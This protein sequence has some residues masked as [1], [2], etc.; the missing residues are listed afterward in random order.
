[1]LSTELSRKKYNSNTQ[2]HA[3]LNRRQKSGNNTETREQFKMPHTSAGEKGCGVTEHVR[4]QLENG[5]D[6][7][8]EAGEGGSKQL[9]Q[10]RATAG[11][12][13]EGRRV[14]EREGEGA[15]SLQEKGAHGT[16]LH[17]H[18]LRN[19]QSMSFTRTHNDQQ[20]NNT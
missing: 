17:T 12:E 8:R 15:E 9:A 7:R 18:T 20:E 6:I 2:K 14:G 11:Q 19:T 10:Q 13:E 5:G 16:P 1:M 3:M 4:E